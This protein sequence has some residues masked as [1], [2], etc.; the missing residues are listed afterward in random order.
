MVDGVKFVENNLTVVMQGSSEVFEV[1]KGE[2]AD[3]LTEKLKGA[4]DEKHR[5]S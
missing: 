4:L 2:S 1:Q 3:F 5:D